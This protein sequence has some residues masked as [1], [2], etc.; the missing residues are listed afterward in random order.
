MAKKIVSML[1]SRDPERDGTLRAPF[2]RD[3]VATGRELK[4][5]AETA[6]GGAVSL[7]GT[8]RRNVVSPTC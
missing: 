6:C 2:F 4:T 1:R 3:T 5:E 7:P 8:I